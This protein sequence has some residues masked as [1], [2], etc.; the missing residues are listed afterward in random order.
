[1]A[2]EKIYETVTVKREIS[3]PIKDLG[4]VLPVA[5]PEHRGGEPRPEEGHPCQQHPAFICMCNRCGSED[6]KGKF[7]ARAQHR[8]D[9]EQAHARV[10]PRHQVFWR[11]L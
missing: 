3:G 1:M 9:V 8:V 6:D 5:R 11:S 2:E 4:N 10:Y 7:R